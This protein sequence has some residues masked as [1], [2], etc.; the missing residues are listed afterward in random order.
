M[1]AVLMKIK[2]L[3]TNFEI[4]ENLLQL[5]IFS[6]GFHRYGSNDVCN[7]LTTEHSVIAM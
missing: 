6:S 2:F 7:V 5:Q 3:V 4:E 1:C